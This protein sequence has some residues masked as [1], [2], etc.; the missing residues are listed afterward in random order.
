MDDSFL[1]WVLSRLERRIWWLIDDK[2][3]DS[4]SNHGCHICCSRVCVSLRFQVYL[5]DCLSAVPPLICVQTFIRCH[6][7]LTVQIFTLMDKSF[8]MDGIIRNAYEFFSHFGTKSL[9][10]FLQ[11]PNSYCTHWNC[12]SVSLRSSCSVTSLL[13]SLRDLIGPIVPN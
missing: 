5:L 12:A 8:W 13:Y 7:F 10:K 4:R 11:H 1:P 9:R 3:F 6:I 2:I